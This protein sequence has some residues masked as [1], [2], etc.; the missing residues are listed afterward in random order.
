MSLAAKK[1]ILRLWRTAKF[2]Y[3]CWFAFFSCVANSRRKENQAEENRYLIWTGDWS[4][5]HKAVMAFLSATVAM[6]VISWIK[7]NSALFL[8]ARIYSTANSK[9]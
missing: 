6:K 5:E 9:S 2:K 4:G 3:N 8:I 7:D 1:R